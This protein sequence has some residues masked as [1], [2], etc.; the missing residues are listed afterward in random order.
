[1]AKAESRERVKDDL[2]SIERQVRNVQQMLDGGGPC[3]ATLAE[4]GAIQTALEHVA[5]RVA[6]LHAE[7]CLA[8]YA[9]EAMRAELARTFVLPAQGP[10]TGH[11]EAS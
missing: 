8:R 5:R 9:P 1:M 3:D 6:G 4:I 11:D 2:A 10:R 7:E